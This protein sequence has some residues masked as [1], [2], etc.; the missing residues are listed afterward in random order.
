MAEILAKPVIGQMALM[1]T[2]GFDIVLDMLK[3]VIVN[4][5]LPVQ[6]MLAAHA[7]YGV[8]TPGGLIPYDSS[9]PMY[10]EVFKGNAVAFLLLAQSGED[11]PAGFASY[12][13]GFGQS[14]FRAGQTLHY[15]MHPHTAPV[16]QGITCLPHLACLL[17]LANLQLHLFA[18]CPSQPRL[19]SV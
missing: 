12:L 10:N 6:N 4:H 17:H 3:D 15:L 14:P 9:S 1:G 11:D 19:S 13:L 18:L 2:G 8:A 16:P 7:G 5:C